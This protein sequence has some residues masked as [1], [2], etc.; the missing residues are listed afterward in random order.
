MQTIDT[1]ITPIRKPPLW[2][3]KIQTR[4]QHGDWLWRA[5]TILMGL[6]VLALILGIGYML[7]YQSLDAQSQ[8]GAK[9]FLPS[10]DS[11]WDPVN[12]VFQVID[13]FS[14]LDGPPPSAYYQLTVPTP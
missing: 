9:F 12:G 6:L 7:W 2:V 13:T 14:D 8:L 3:R 1:P 11:S 5:L 10:S 4:F